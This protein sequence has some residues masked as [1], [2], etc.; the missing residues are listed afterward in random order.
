M[1]IRYVYTRKRA[2]F[3]KQCNFSDRASEIHADIPPNPELAEKFILRN[4]VSRGIQHA[5]EMSE[6]EVNTE[7][8][9]SEVRGINHTEGGWPK[10][11]NYNE[12]EQVQRYRKKIEKDE[13]Y[14][15]T[16]HALASSVEHCIKQN[17]ALN[18]YEEYFNDIDYDASEEPPSARIV[19]VFRDINDI[20]RTAAY[21][22]WFPEGPTKIAVAYSNIGFLENGAD[23]STDSYIWDFSNP[24]RP[25]LVLSPPSSLVCVEFNPKD[26]HTLVGGCHNGQLCLWDRRK[27]SLPAE[28]SPV[29]N[30]H[31]DP[32]WQVIW[33]QSKTGTEFFSASTDG[34]VLWWDVRK[35]NEPTEI[36]Y[37]DPTKNQELNCSV[38]AYALEYEPTIPTKFMAGTEQGMIISCNR[39]GKSPAEKVAAVFSGHK[40]PV[41]ALQRNPFFTKFFLSVGDWSARIWSED[42]KDDPIMW[43]PYHD[44]GATDGR[45]SPVRPALFFM[46]R[47]NGCLE[48]WDYVFKQR[49]PALTIKV[50]DDSLHCVRVNEEGQLVAVGSHSGVTTILELSDGFTTAAKNEKATVGAMFERETHREKIL[51][52]RAKELRVKEK[53]RAM[54]EAAAAG[55]PP[56]YTQGSRPFE[57]ATENAE[58]AEKAEVADGETLVKKAEDKEE[59]EEKEEG[60]AS[61]EELLSPEELLNKVEQDFFET[62]DEERRKRERDNS[63]RS[64]R[65][66]S[67]NGAGDEGEEE[68]EEEEEDEATAD[69]QDGNEEG[70]DSEGEEED[71][72]DIEGEAR[73]IEG[74][75]LAVGATDGAET[76]D[77][78]P[79]EENEVIGKGG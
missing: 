67:L 78:A 57:G 54:A 72:E 18:I 20:K 75:G 25:D 36:L 38:G 62:I 44:S 9:L 33:I 55:A 79:P 19:N 1:N 43:T 70:E 17:N 11:V 7:R 77:R 64:R 8:V 59:E 45:W 41:Y 32:A 56:V 76:S 16:L 47:L 10:D 37:L 61:A 39:K 26:S 50:S 69:E 23:V 74:E 22:S 3:G 48:I 49:E 14:T 60:E 35:M 30:S 5:S 53:Q 66:E 73:R 40:G 6:H 34:Q 46:T 29:E 27:G 68:E 65:L 58:K 13:L 15:V 42:M 12:P 71:E 4:P 2:D 28:L 21:V 31:R 63:E 51:E 24:N 52:T